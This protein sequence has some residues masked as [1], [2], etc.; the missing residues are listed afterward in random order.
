MKMTE[1]AAIVNQGLEG[2][3]KNYRVEAIQNFKNG[4]LKDALKINISGNVQPVL[5]LTETDNIIY[6]D[7]AK[8]I[9]YAINTIPDHA[10][11]FNITKYSILEN[12]KETV[13]SATWEMPKDRVT[14]PVMNTSL[15][16]VFYVEVFE[17]GRFW[18][19]TE[20]LNKFE[21]SNRE[22]FDNALHNTESDITIRNISDIL[23][24]ILGIYDDPITNDLMKIVSN[25]SNT[26]GASILADSEIAELVSERTG[27]DDYMI[28]PSSI[29]ECI[30]IPYTTDYEALVEMV[31]S[32]NSTE[33][34]ED[35]ILSD[36]VYEYRYGVIKELK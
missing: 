2:D 9:E 29:H 5:Y 30:I 22:L 4:K 11:A 32:V 18:I 8:Q 14:I 24:P 20:M 34:K 3:R 36:A 31:K 10:D 33:L 28:I 23:N 15:I 1:I 16:K 21:I 26:Y 25:K 7:I 27:W 35:E 6:G 17:G 19:T 13:L 12:V